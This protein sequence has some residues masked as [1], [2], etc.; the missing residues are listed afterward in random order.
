MTEPMYVKCPRCKSKVLVTP[1][2]PG[3][4]GHWTLEISNTT[5]LPAKVYADEGLCQAVF[6]QC[7]PCASPY[8]NGKYQGQQAE[9][10]LP[11]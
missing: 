2:E 7:A 11:R 3:W 6:F 8:A 10:T 1:G 5:P 4:E 9:V